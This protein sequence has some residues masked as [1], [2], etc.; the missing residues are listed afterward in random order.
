PTTPDG[1]FLPFLPRSH[2]FER[3]CGYYVTILAG[4]RTAY[5]RSISQLSQDL[6]TIRPT[7]LVSVPRIYERVWGAIG[8]KLDEG[9]PFRK[10]L[11][12][13]AVE[14]GYARFEHAQGRGA[15]KPSFL[16]WPLLD[17]LVASKVRERLGGRMKA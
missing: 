9:P 3:T 2:R 6:Q 8:A 17:K 1:V 11:F 10:K 16:L 5:A 7:V 4:A 13:L 12:L 14:V 15:W